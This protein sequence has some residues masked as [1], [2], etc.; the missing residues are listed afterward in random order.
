MTEDNSPTKKEIGQVE[1][2]E[3]YNLKIRRK[4]DNIKEEYKRLVLGLI[5]LIFLVYAIYLLF[6]SIYHITDMDSGV[7]NESVNN[8]YNNISK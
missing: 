1:H 8:V 6:S 4:I 7:I 2:K 3:G 5:L